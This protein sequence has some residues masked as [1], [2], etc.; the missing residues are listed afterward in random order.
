MSDAPGATCP[1]CKTP[2][3]ERFCGRCGTRVPAMRPAS[4]KPHVATTQAVPNLVDGA[5]REATTLWALLSKPF[6][7]IALIP[8]RTR[9]AAI[10]LALVGAVPLAAAELTKSAPVQYWA[11]AI[12]FSLLWAGFFAVL[13]HGEGAQPRIAAA[14]YFGTG[15]CSLALVVVLSYGLSQAREPYLQSTNPFVVLAGFILGVGI[16]EELVKALPLFVLCRFVALPPLQLFIY[17]GLISGLGFGLYEGIAYQRHTILDST[18]SQLTGASAGERTLALTSYYIANVLRLTSAPFFHAVWTGIAAFLIWFGM[19]FRRHRLSFFALAIGVPAI[20]HGLYDGFLALHDP[21]V[22]VLV[23]LLSAA[24]L[25]VFVGSAK[26]LEREIGYRCRARCAVAGTGMTGAPAQGAAVGI[27]GAPAADG[28]IVLPLK[29]GEGPPTTMFAAESPKVV[30][31]NGRHDA[32]AEHR[33]LV[34]DRDGV[35]AERVD[36]RVAREGEAVGGIR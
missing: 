11:L 4:R 3:A 20:F 1:N 25:G 6:R 16:P 13:Y 5:Y 21:A 26:E 36:D 24:L 9:R 23:A 19:R 27:G 33:A 10:L 32:E 31:G 34:C 18:V 17:Y 12:Y 14:M 28:L 35:R 30:I 29:A 15:V 8:R 2:V 22:T 7:R